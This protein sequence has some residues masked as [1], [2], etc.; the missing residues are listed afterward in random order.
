MAMRADVEGAVLLI[1]T[2]TMAPKTFSQ[3]GG[4]AASDGNVKE[5]SRSG[6]DGAIVTELH[7]ERAVCI[8]SVLVQAVFRVD[9]G[10]RGRGVGQS[11][12]RDACE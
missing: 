8:D 11:G 2:C 3:S 6:K 1:V 4:G 9:S 7:H 12:G 5:A 10:E